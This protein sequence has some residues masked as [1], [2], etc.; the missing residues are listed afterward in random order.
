MKNAKLNSNDAPKI[1]AP[2]VTKKSVVIQML[3]EDGG[4]TIN[5]MAQKIVDI[6]RD[7]DYEKNQRVVRL[8]LSKIGFK[9]VRDVE[10]K[11][12]TPAPK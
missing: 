4:A 8:W 11:K 6:G 9:V 10:T 3:N 1:E 7:A 2:K 5:E 12:Y